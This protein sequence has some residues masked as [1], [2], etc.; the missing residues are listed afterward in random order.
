MAQTEAR[1][2]M[3]NGVRY[4][5][6][7]AMPSEYERQAM[8][9]RRRRRMAEMLAAQAYQPQEGG[10]APIPTAAP[11]VQGLQAFLAARAERKAGES[12]EAAKKAGQKEFADYIRSFE[13]E[14][15]KVGVGDVAAMEAAIP[16]LDETGR[17]THIAPSAIAAPNQ[18]L[19]PAMT[20]TGEIDVNQPMQMQVGGPLSMA[21][22]RARALEGFESTN[23]MV[24][25]Y[26]A[27]QYD[28]S[29]PK[30]LALKLA[31]IDPTKVDMA[32][33]AEA[34]RTGNIGLIKPRAKLPEEM[35]PYEKAQIDIKKEELE[36]KKRRGGGEERPKAPS[37]YRYD[38]N[39]DLEA[40]P[41]GPQDPDRERPLPGSIAI[42]VTQEKNKA[43]RFTQTQNKTR[44]FI[45][46]IKNGELPLSKV[47]GLKY[48]SQRA[49]DAARNEEGAPTEPYVK[50]YGLLRFV[51]QQVNQ[52]L[53][54]A[55]GP[56]TEGDALRARQQIL[57]N[58]DNEK[59][60]LSALEDLD[61]IWQNEI[62][63][64][65]AA[66]DDYQSEYRRPKKDGIIDL[67]PRR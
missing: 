29:K 62:D 23:P 50:Y 48:A 20:Q 18:K 7:F 58:P 57:D 31:D 8:E 28:A 41:G 37:G 16:Q 2:K 33:V 49:F 9:A 55:K 53:Q 42:L 14:E 12:E 59:I 44:Q 5:P 40:I 60:V 52:I 47:S 46:T 3:S 43:L 64:A 61:S 38:A 65:N 11:L 26:A 19:M 13:P 17:L 6:T 32:T 4:T 39:G 10:V 35:T 24:Q 36:L 56:Q 45:N 21:Q 66:A 67:P 34:E 27:A 51:D 30:T 1:L 54:A 22:R 15:R 63:L 25:Q